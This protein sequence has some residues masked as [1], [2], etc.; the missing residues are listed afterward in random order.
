M[1]NVSSARDS[2]TNTV[3]ALW[4]VR[5]IL[6]DWQIR[7]MS[8]SFLAQVPPAELLTRMGATAFVVVAVALAVSHFGPIIGGAL[9]GLPIILGP[10][11]FFL[12]TRTSSSF[13][14]NAAAYSVFALCATQIFLLTY[15]VTAKRAPPVLSLCAAIGAWLAAAI[16][17]QF[18]PPDPLIGLI[19]FF[20][21]TRGA[22]CISNRFY[23]DAPKGRRNERL[24]LLLLRGGLAGLLVAI[25]TAGASGMGPEWSGI[26]LS[27]PIGYTVIAVTIHEQLGR[28]SAITTLRSALLGTT[29][30]VGFCATLSLTVEVMP[31]QGAFVMAIL[32]SLSITLGLIAQSQQ[33]VT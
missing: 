14:A 22:R 29:S 17:F 20:G 2:L 5:S 32:V 1:H 12:I 7:V 19:L 9:A 25:V 33:Q 16:P 15:I 24:A 23:F 10:G 11:F 30:L 13:V 18:L 6:G 26:F 3:A 28:G 27:F 4:Y 21:L 8:V 31:A